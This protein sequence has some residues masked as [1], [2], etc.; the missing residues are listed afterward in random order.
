MPPIDGPFA[1]PGGRVC[2]DSDVQR[3]TAI[4]RMKTFRCMAGIDYTAKTRTAA[5]R[6]DSREDRAMES[7]TRRSFFKTL[8]L[9]AAGVMALRGEAAADAAADLVQAGVKRASEPSALKVT[10]VRVAVV[11]GA[12]MTCPL[13]RVDTNQ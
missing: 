6:P 3:H 10:D 1:T 13:I 7:A 9:G 5:D 12:P 4:A 8:G 11:T 2:A